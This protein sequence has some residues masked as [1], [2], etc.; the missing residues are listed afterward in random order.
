MYKDLD[1]M[2]CLQYSSFQ[3]IVWN[4]LNKPAARHDSLGIMRAIKSE[5]TDGALKAIERFKTEI[6][7]EAESDIHIGVS[8]KNPGCEKVCFLINKIQTAFIFSFLSDFFDKMKL[9]L[10]II[11]LLTIKRFEILSHIQLL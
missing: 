10:S 6:K 8:C 5:V 3:V 1:A 9:S 11:S 2:A 4:G 7:E